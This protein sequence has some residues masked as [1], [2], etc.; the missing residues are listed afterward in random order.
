[1]V[2]A[3]QAGCWKRHADID[4]DSLVVAGLIKFSVPSCHDRRFRE[5]D[6]DKKSPALMPKEV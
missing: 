1:M 5:F 6:L 2:L 3:C 4:R